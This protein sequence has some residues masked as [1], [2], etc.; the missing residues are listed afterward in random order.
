[1][2]HRHTDN[3][4]TFHMTCNGFH[5][6]VHHNVL[7][8]YGFIFSGGVPTCPVSLLPLEKLSGTGAGR[9]ISKIG[10]FQKLRRCCSNVFFKK[11]I[12]DSGAE[13]PD[14]VV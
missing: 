9:G 13:G 10:E 1:M 4:A 7:E 8:V 5:P 12:P 6:R 14:L 2:S 11:K 3:A